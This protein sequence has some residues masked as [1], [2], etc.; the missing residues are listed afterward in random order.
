GELIIRKQPFEAL[1]LRL[2]PAKARIAQL[3]SEYPASFVVFDLLADERGRSMLQ[4][5][6]FKR[7]DALQEFF[8]RIGKNRA[9][10]LSRARTSRAKA[11][12]W[13][14]GE[15]RGGLDG[16]MAK[17]LNE[18]Y[19]SGQRV[20]LK[21]KLR[22]TIDCVVAGFYEDEKTGWVNSLLLGLYDADGLLHYVGHA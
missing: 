17:P 20:M 18:P 22:Q 14:R 16:I 9:L 19:R 5:P 2:H 12:K 7:R 10:I 4:E 8:K 21:Y 3:V 13:R 11:L 1:Q 6:F 15:E